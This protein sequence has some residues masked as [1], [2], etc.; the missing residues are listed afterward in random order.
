MIRD[1][2]KKLLPTNPEQEN[3]IYVA[4]YF[5]PSCAKKNGTVTINGANFDPIEYTHYKHFSGNPE[6]PPAPDFSE[7]NDLRFVG[8]L[9]QASLH[10]A[11]H[12]TKQAGFAKLEA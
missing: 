2:F 9:H 6:H 4:Y 1:L 5:S 10:S 11:S 8:N 12:T 7:Y 3:G